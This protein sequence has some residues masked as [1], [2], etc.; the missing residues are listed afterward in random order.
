MTLAIAGTACARKTVARPAGQSTL[1]AFLAAA[2]V[3][4]LGAMIGLGGARFRLPLL[5]G[6]FGSSCCKR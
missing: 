4:L 3:G 1:L 2:A 6:L 5:I